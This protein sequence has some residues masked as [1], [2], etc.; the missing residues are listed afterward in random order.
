MSDAIINIYC[1]NQSAIC[2]SK[3]PMFHDRSNNIDVRLHF[4][5][6]IIEQRIISIFKI[7]TEENPS[8]IL[9]KLVPLVKFK[10]CL[11]LHKNC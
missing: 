2:L 8:N 10:L 9:T 11:D 1:H 6:D 7:P 3:N 5:R 4:V